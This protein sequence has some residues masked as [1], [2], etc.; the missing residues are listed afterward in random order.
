MLVRGLERSADNAES[1]RA[2]CRPVGSAEVEVYPGVRSLLDVGASVS[3]LPPTPPSSSTS[4]SA[5]A[6]S[7]LPG[8]CCIG[9]DA[10]GGGSSPFGLVGSRRKRREPSAVR[11]YICCEGDADALFSP[12]T[13]F[14]PLKLARESL[15]RTG[16]EGDRRRRR[17]GLGRYGW[18]A[19]VEWA[20]G[21]VIRMYDYLSFLKY[22]VCLVI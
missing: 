10:Y 2:R 15:T 5:S 14:T 3:P 6:S 1:V 21:R 8:I 18:E 19:E 16:S 9:K 13:S 4:A 22:L 11:T 17:G 12:F 7:S 20:W